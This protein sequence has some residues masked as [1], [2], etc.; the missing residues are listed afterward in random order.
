M[1]LK[2]IKRNPK[3]VIYSALYNTNE[4]NLEADEERK[5]ICQELPTHELDE[6]MQNLNL[7]IIEQ[8]E[9]PK[10]W[11]EGLV[12]HGFTMSYTKHGTASMQIIFSK[13][14]EQTGG[15][16][17]Q[18]KTPMFRIERPSDGEDGDIETSADNAR[19]C[20]EA[21]TQ[22]EMYAQGHRSQMTFDE[23]NEQNGALSNADSDETEQLI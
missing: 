21:L 20:H 10:T 9:L 7:V 16:A 17:H 15:K 22:A 19:R 18:I 5:V 8:L 11:V 13:Q 14:L 1:K 6:A 23:W 12:V 3:N 2:S 4:D